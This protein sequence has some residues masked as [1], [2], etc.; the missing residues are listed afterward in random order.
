MIKVAISGYSGFISQNLEKVLKRYEYS[1]LGIR[2]ELLYSPM[3]LE[4]FYQTNQPEF[5]VHTAAYGNKFD[6]TND[7]ETVVSNILPLMNLLEVTK[8]F[9]YTGL[10][11]FSSSSVAL[12][13]ETF[14]SASKGAGERIVRAFVNKYQKPVVNVRPFTVIGKG[15]Q[16]E[17]LIPKLIESCQTNN[18]IPFV[19]EPT[20]DFVGVNDFC[21][22]IATILQYTQALK[23]STI[24]IGTGV[25]TTND[26][27]RQIVEAKVGKKANVD[28]K[29]SMRPYDTLEWKANPVILESMGWKPK[30]TL[31]Q[32]IEDMV[33]GNV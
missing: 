21:E 11:N 14:Y 31:E 33:R 17:H 13:Y 23:G 15:E 26:Q 7:Y 3:L 32:I 25:S 9:N 27:V 18:P 19:P 5:T 22:A 1:V 10:I 6:Q 24:D 30:Q 29:K 2:R 28:I 8:N 16:K 12:P 4:E 20:H